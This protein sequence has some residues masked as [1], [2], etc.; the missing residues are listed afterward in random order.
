MNLHLIFLLNYTKILSI[1]Q[2]QGEIFLKKI[3]I[4][5]IIFLSGTVFCS[6]SAKKTEKAD[7]TIATS[8]VITSMEDFTTESTASSEVSASIKPESIVPDLDIKAPE[9]GKLIYDN[10]GVL[11]DESYKRCSDYLSEL[12]NGYMLNAA[13]ITSN[14]LE[15]RS[16]YE[17]AEAAYKSVFGNGGNGLLLLINN[18]TNEDYLYKTGAC[19]RFISENDEKT[20]FYSATREIVSGDYESAVLR[21]MQLG[22]SCPE[23]I[24]D[25]A[26]VF[27]D[28]EISSLEEKI[29]SGGKDIFFVTVN[30]SEND[31]ELIKNLYKRRYI[32]GGGCIIMLDMNTNELT[33]YSDSAVPSEV[34]EAVAEVNKNLSVQNILHIFSEHFA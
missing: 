11:N 33:V 7:L 23:H 30:N 24:C 19:S 14:D 8:A 4:A 16:V 22:K 2:E 18:D 20:A 28:E 31:S 3:S 13:V 12:Y 5:V 25:Y 1:L 17:Y 21:I 10:A 6:C 29:A 9:E 27:S 34:T 15:G 26:S 32:N